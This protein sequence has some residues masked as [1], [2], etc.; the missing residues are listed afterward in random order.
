MQQALF[1]ALKDLRMD[2]PRLAQLLKIDANRDIASWIHSVDAKLL[3]R[4]SPDFPVVAA[5]CGGG[6][7]GKSTLFNTLLRGKHAPTGGKA[8]MNRRVLF[9]VPADRVAEPGLLSGLV[10]PF[11]SEP[12][13]LKDIQD[14]STPGNPLYILNSSASPNLVLLDTPD[15]DTGANGRYINREVTR[16]ALEASDILIYIFTNSNYNN[17]DNT[18]FVSRMLT[19]IGRRKCFL[20]YR[21]YPSFSEQEIYEHS[22]TVARGI[23]GDEAEKFLLGIYR[24]DEDN[25]VAAG[26]RF[27]QL[28]P[29]VPSG[30]PITEAL[31]SIDAPKLRFELHAS[32]LTDVLK[33]SEEILE[34]TRI[35]LD[36]LQLYRDAFQTAQ[37]HWVHEALKHFPMDSVMGRFAL[38]W[39]KSDPA[40]IKFMR[41]TGSLIELPLKMVSVAAAW[42][43]Y[44]IRVENAGQPPSGDFQEKLEEGL[45]TATTNLHLQVVGPQMSATNAIT[46]PVARRML[47]TTNRIRAKE[48]LEKAQNP[49]AESSDDGMVFT[50]FVDPHPVVLPHQEDLRDQDFKSILQTI[51]SHKDDLVEISQDMDE[52]LKELAEHFRSEMGLWAKISQTFW[53]SLNVLPAT[54]AVSYVLSTGDPVGAAGIK[55]KLSGLIGAKDLYALFAIPITTGL[56]LADQKQLEV[57]LGPIAKTWFGH[58]LKKVQHLFE[59]NITGDMIKAANDAVAKATGMISEIA[60]GIDTCAAI[61]RQK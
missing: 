41:K 21:V 46:D 17:R 27:M 19:G 24:A 51:L 59:Q 43:K 6:S 23:Y 29:V 18:D 36:Q 40:L 39:S 22:M 38:I 49:R 13:P 14:L 25:R 12:A 8:G 58:K 33:R 15:F 1:D 34:E 9:S 45:I 60:K 61:V 28:S 44:Q 4:F 3:K 54:V 2:I 30:L 47:E 10:E 35:S 31:L 53:A 48:N 5:V 20:I 56:K 55:V 57:M 50:F 7:S 52:E 37:S 16:M 42:I 26:D 32:I 11:K